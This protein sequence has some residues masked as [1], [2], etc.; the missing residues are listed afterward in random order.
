MERRRSAGFACYLDYSIQR[1]L[2]GTVQNTTVFN[3]IADELAR[4]GYQRDAKQ[5]REKLKQLKKKYK[6]V[7]DGLRRSGAGVDSDDE[8]EEGGYFVSFRWFSKIHSV[9]GGESIGYTSS[10]VGYILNYIQEILR[11]DQCI[12][13]MY[14]NACIGQR[15]I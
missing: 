12:H 5:C 13:I 4:K 6:E 7:V 1:Q 15:T 11:G 2:L 9:M 8:F 3:K 14:S 10:I